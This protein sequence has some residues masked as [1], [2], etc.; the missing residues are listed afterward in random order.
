MNDD[1]ENELS[2]RQQG[3]IYCYRRVVIFGEEMRR[4]VIAV[5]ATWRWQ[6]DQPSLTLG[7]EGNLLMH[8]PI[9]Y[10]VTEAENALGLA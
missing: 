1:L 3:R 9:E 10:V 5:R 8:N 7:G 2:E 4:E 6:H